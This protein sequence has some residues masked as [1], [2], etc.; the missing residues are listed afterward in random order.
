VQQRPGARRPHHDDGYEKENTMAPTANNTKRRET[1]GRRSLFGL[2][3]LNVT[4]AGLA[5]MSLLLYACAGTSSASTTS[6]A[7]LRADLAYARCMRAHGVTNFPDP[8]SQGDFPPFQT[9][10]SKQ[11]SDAAQH[12]CQYLL[13]SGGGGGGGA[14]TGKDQK[15][16][17]F[18]LKV[19]QCMRRHGYPSYPDPTNPTNPSQGSGTRFRGT[20]INTK[21]PQFQTAETNCEKQ[22]AKAL[23]IGFPGAK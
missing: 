13:P 19:A 17:D 6:P 14:G 18:F 16:L 8:N 21:S 2:R 5:S 7:Q 3:W 10:V 1:R 9:H 11:T 23:G 22:S 4:I 20:G 12:A 15:K